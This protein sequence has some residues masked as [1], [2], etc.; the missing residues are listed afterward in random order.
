MLIHEIVKGIYIVYTAQGEP[1]DEQM[2][3]DVEANTTSFEDE[4]EEFKY[5]PMIAADLRD[6]I[7]ENKLVEEFPYLRLNI[8]KELMLLETDDFINL[9]AGIL[10]KTPLA[11][12]RIDSIIEKCYNEEK[13]YQDQL[14]Q[15]ERDMEKYQRDLEEFNNSKNDI[16]KDKNEYEE[17][18]DVL[19]DEEDQEDQT[20]SNIYKNNKSDKDDYS[21]W[22]QRDLQSELDNA[23]DNGDYDKARA[24]SKFLK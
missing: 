3:K 7:N 8:F 16:S 1:E 17:D 4:A 14:N 20:L 23:L 11:R 21:T 2:A 5:G 15:Y 19:D 22:S 13:E 18:G 12:R 10:S 6:F 24:V 9:F